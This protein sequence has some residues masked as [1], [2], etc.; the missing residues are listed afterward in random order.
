MTGDMIA[1]IAPAMSASG[2]GIISIS[3]A[4]RKEINSK[5]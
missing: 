2:N 1:A 3:G 5:E 4:G